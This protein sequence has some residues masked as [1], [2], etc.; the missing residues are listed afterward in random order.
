[1]LSSAGRVTLAGVMV[2]ALALGGCA[3][4]DSVRHAQATADQAL[5]TAQQAQ[6]AATHAQQTADAAGSAAQ[7]AQQTAD[8]GASTAQAAASQ[9]QAASAQAANAS[10]QAQEAKQRPTGKAH[11]KRRH[12]R[13]TGANAGERG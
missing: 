8:A 7:R 10:A 3:T 11:H 13:A 5:S 6:G 2:G 4:N 1:M 9:A 12:H